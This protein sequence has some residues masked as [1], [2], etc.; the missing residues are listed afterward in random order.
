MPR[1]EL[2]I[3]SELY[4]GTGSDRGGGAG[5]SKTEEE[6]YQPVTP[7]DWEKPAEEEEEEEDVGERQ[8]WP[9]QSPNKNLIYSKS[10]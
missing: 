6:G 5:S 8:R 4:G 9:I 3:L 7:V 2:Y 1:C 10:Q